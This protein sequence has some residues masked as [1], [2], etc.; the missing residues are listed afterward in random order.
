MTY[1]M[2][3]NYLIA[4]LF[5]V[6]ALLASCKKD[7]TEPVQTGNNIQFDNLAVGQQSK[8]LGLLGEKYFESTWDD[9]VYT[10]DT[11]VLEVVSHDNLGFKVAESLH[12]VGDVEPWMA[13]EKDSV[14]Y[15][16]LNVVNDS[17]KVQPIGTNF[18]QSRIWTYMVENNG[19]PLL[20]IQTQKV[21]IQGWKTDLSY[22]ECYREGYTENYTLFG[23]LYDRLNVVV[24]NTPMALDGAGSTYAFSGK[25]G[26]VR[27]STYG[28]WTQSGYG[29]DL[30]PGE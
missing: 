3:T 23:E 6:V 7:P 10:D 21:Q 2:R 8:Y 16:Y 26:A 20:P 5:A 30:L 24:D 11:L 15:Y 27:F 4:G 18:V 17:L 1:I 22:C 13:Q 9:F 12:Y 29:W 19:L 28:W 14:Y 25:H